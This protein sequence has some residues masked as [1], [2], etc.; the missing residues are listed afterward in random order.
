MRFR[1]MPDNAMK[2]ISVEVIAKKNTIAM[3]VGKLKP[4]EPKGGMNT[5]QA[6]PPVKSATATAAR[7]DA[8]MAVNRIAGKNVTKGKPAGKISSTANRNQV[9]KTTA[10]VAIRNSV[11]TLRCSDK[12]RE[13]A[14]MNEDH[15]MGS[16]EVSAA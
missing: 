5:P 6:I 11:R 16:R 2:K 15:S 14:T 4:N 12:S 13:S 10:Q 9:E 8:K 7:I 1:A 3:T